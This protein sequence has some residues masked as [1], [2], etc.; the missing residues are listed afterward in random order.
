MN[1]SIIIAVI[2]SLLVL[3]VVITGI[4][5]KREQLAAQRK[6]QA[7]QYSYRAQQAQ[8]MIELMRSIPVSAQIIQFL[9][10]LSLQSLK[11]AASIWP[12]QLN[13]SHEI[14]KAEMRLQGY[15]PKADTAIPLPNDEQG[16]S[17]TTARL[18]KLLQYLSSLKENAIL[19]ESHFTPWKKKLNR[20]LARVDIEGLLKLATRAVEN[21]KPGTANNYLN[22]AKTRFDLYELEPTYKNEQLQ[23]LLSIEQ[24]LQAE[25]TVQKNQ[26]EPDAV[27]QPEHSDSIFPDKKKW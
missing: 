5:Q 12:G 6:Q 26:P 22:L 13:I 11:M 7:A 17:L 25:K 20:D 23:L 1:I 19:P 18:K 9:L 2:V 24:Q 27:V 16:L 14:E 3:S 8:E 15:K 4:I 10:N 21:Q